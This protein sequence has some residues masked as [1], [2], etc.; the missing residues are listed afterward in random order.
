MESRGAVFLGHLLL[1]S[2]LPVALR[3]IIRVTVIIRLTI[4][5]LLYYK[6][7]KAISFKF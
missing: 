7:M 6:A 4:G 5:L 3:V 2:G 1:Q